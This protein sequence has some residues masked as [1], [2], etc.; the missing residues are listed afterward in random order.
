[1]TT[2]VAIETAVEQG[3][4]TEQVAEQRSP[5]VHGLGELSLAL[6]RDWAPLLKPAG[7]GLLT[8]IHAWEEQNPRSPFYGWMHL[9][10]ETLAAYLDMGRTSIIRYRNLLDTCGLIEQR[11]VS[12]HRPGMKLHQT[13]LRVSR[14]EVQP[15]L[16]LLEYLIF[17]A[18][19]WTRKHTAWLMTN[20][21]PPRD[22]SELGRLIATMRRAY[23]VS[24]G[25]SGLAVI[26]DGER[27]TAAGSFA[28]RLLQ[29]ELG[30]QPTLL[31]DEVESGRGVASYKLQVTT[32]M[33]G[34]SVV[35][36]VNNGRREMAVEPSATFPI[37]ESS[38][39]RVN[40]GSAS[41][42]SAGV[43]G[44]QG[45]VSPGVANNANVSLAINVKDSN[46]VNVGGESDFAIA[47]QGA[48]RIADEGSVQWHIACLQRMGRTLYEQAIAAT[49]R[50]VVSGKLRGKSGG[51]FT[52]T[53]MALAQQQGIALKQGGEAGSYKLKVDSGNSVGSPLNNGVSASPATYQPSDVSPLNNGEQ[54][55]SGTPTRSYT[56][57]GMAARQA[58]QAALAELE[59]RLSGPAWFGWLRHAHL[60][61]LEG[62]K[63]VVGTPS[64]GL[65]EVMTRRHAAEVVEVM[66]AVLGRAVSVE[67]VTRW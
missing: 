29:R 1:M 3:E 38:V 56:L 34:E 51:Y 28:A 35:S 8:T 4:T 2:R 22:D 44:R 10:Q 40:N 24:V 21:Q 54:A 9:A 55:N 48:R 6:V 27:L 67:F 47:T 63:A 65:A 14:A 53:A 31:L 57:P 36:P 62:D 32:G 50:V 42:V 11:E 59:A 5:V 66:S 46:N 30:N 18:E 16:R 41:G 26:T 17:E 20:F 45:I 49:E 43:V 39:S 61:E 13:V 58:W 19:D 25:G 52:R 12:Y 37:D 64:G 7:V 23:K 60:L 15:S 33:A